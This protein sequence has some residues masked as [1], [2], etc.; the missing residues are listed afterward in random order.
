MSVSKILDEKQGFP[1]TVIT[2]AQEEPK[3]PHH[4]PP[5]LVSIKLW[6]RQGLDAV[7]KGKIE[8]MRNLQF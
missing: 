4:P 6:F 5:R 3:W 1:T 2:S 7:F 8:E